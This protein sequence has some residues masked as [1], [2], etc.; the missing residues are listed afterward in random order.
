MSRKQDLGPGAKKIELE[1]RLNANQNKMEQAKSTDST[2]ARSAGGRR[3][4]QTD[5]NEAV[6]EALDKSRY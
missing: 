6:R 4:N 2:Q 5:P 3:Q 1:R